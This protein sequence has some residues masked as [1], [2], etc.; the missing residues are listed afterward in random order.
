MRYR[1]RTLLIFLAIAPF[2]L[3]A[4]SANFLALPLLNADRAEAVQNVVAWIVEGRPMQGFGD[5][6][7]DVKGMLEKKHVFVVCE[8]LSPRVAVSDDSRVQRVTRA[9]LDNKFKQHGFS[10]S[11]YMVIEVKGESRYILILEVSNELGNMGGHG[12]QFEFR[13]KLW[14]LRAKGKMLWVS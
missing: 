2:A 13:R 5:S 4:L 7:P 12:Y 9:E 14:G 3:G 11:D 1:L 10:E 8:C 6:Y